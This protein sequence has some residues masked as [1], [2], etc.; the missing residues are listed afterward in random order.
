M[1]SKVKQHL[2]LSSGEGQIVWEESHQDA[3]GQ[4]LKVPGM[5]ILNISPFFMGDKMRMPVRLRYRVRG[6]SIIWLYQIFR[7]DQFVTEHI[8]N[9]LADARARTELPTFEGSPEMSA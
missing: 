6:G 9:T 2:A 7:P 8:R 4:A 3:S 5:F 1:S